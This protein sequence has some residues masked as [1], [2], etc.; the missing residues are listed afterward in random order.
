M[1]RA[2]YPR[3]HPAVGF[4]RT[5]GSAFSSALSEPG[6][7]SPPIWSCTARGLPCLRHC[8]RSGGLLPHLFTLTCAAF[9]WKMSRRFSSGLSPGYA[10][11]AVYSLWHFPWGSHFWPPP[12]ALPGA[13]PYSALAKWCPDFPPTSPP[14]PPGELRPGQRSSNSPAILHYTA[15]TRR[16]AGFHARVFSKECTT[17]NSGYTTASSRVP[18]SLQAASQTPLPS[19]SLR[20]VLSPCRTSTR[21]PS[22]PPRNPSSY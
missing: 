2:T 10:P 14:P 1:D 17:T 13:L 8:C 11:P 9:H 7:L 15:L 19:K 16:S 4:R 18:I 5:E 20:Q 12:L 22:L 6:Q 3:V 21:D